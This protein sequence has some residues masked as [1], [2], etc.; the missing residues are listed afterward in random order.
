[1]ATITYT[2][3]LNHLILTVIIVNGV[4]VIGTSLTYS[5]EA[6]HTA[7]GLKGHA[8][9]WHHGNCTVV[10]GFSWCSSTQM[11]LTKCQAFLLL[12][13]LYHT[14]REIIFLYLVQR[15]I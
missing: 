4:T 2:Y 13:G 15:H 10:D 5:M 9:T 3:T 14:V 12:T 8:V 1:M 7:P 6:H 11:G